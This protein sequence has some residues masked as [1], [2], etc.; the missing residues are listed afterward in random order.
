MRHFNTRQWGLFFA[1]VSAA[2]LAAVFVSQYGFG[3]HPC[4][5]CIWQ[6]WPYA[7]SFVLGGLLV[8]L[9][10]Y[11][12]P[13]RLIRRVLP[14]VFLVSAGLALF[15]FGVE[16]KWWQFNSDCTGTA[17][18]PGAST[19]EILEALQHAPTVRCDQ[20]APFLFGLSMS[21]YNIVTSVV[22]LV[23]SLY[24]LRSNSLSQYK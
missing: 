5:L 4:K 9:S 7:V 8:V 21:F 22:L 10:D 11:P 14:V 2:V 20:V 6:R 24:S 15:H 18:K 13:A 12:N 23:L 16:Q 3:L 17:F 19:S 1:A